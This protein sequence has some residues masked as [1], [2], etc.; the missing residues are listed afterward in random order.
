M[1]FRQFFGTVKT[2]L[3][4]LI[5][6]ASVA[7]I[8][9]DIALLV[10][11]EYITATPAVA[12]VSMVA[13]VLITVFALLMVLN[14]FYKFREKDL[15]SCLAFF[16][17]KI[18]YEDI[19]GIK[20]NSETNDIYLIIRAFKPSQPPMAFRMNLKKGREEEFLKLLKEKNPS[21]AVETFEP[22]KKK[23]K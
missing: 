9:V 19:I 22:K 4:S 18:R 17:D 8:G 10:G 23:N 15:Y 2:V 5:A 13:A 11:K 1:K 12:I 20:Q 21:L 3:I 7:I 14:S 6:A 16:V